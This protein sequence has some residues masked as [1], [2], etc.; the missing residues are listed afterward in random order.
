MTIYVFLRVIA[1]RMVH[2]RLQDFPVFTPATRHSLRLALQRGSPVG[3]RAV[4][5]RPTRPSACC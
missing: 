5:V 1:A 2:G 3:L 4:S